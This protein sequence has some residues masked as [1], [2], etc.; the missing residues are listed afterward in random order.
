MNPIVR[1]GK[2]LEE[3]IYRLVA[4]RRGSPS[5]TR[6]AVAAS[7]EAWREISRGK[8][9]SAITWGRLAIASDPSYPEG[10]VM[11]GFAHARSG[12][13]EEGRR[14][15][16]EGIRVAPDYGR[17]AA[18]LGELELGLRRWSE[19][20]TSLRRAVDLDRTEVAWQLNL[21]VALRMQDK[22]EEAAAVLRSLLQV[23]PLEARALGS[24]GEICLHTGDISAAEELLTA[25][26]G[27][28]PA[29]AVA[30]DNLARL[31]ARTGRWNEALREARQAVSLKPEDE[32][33]VALLRQIE[34]RLADSNAPG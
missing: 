33:F 4:T 24:L 30:H 12:Q 11:L 32:E 29:L 14:V 20:E 7:R 1:M 27:S 23:A 13:P 9:A 25:A 15:Y 31:L 3:T 22:I 18:S 28:D 2:V 6:D 26:I 5:A 34:E 10:Y 16:E 19:A 8:W 17:L 21:A